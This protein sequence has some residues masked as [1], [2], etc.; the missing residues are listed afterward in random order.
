MYRIQSVN[1]LKIPTK[2]I[3]VILGP[4][5]VGKTTLLRNLY[6]DATYINIEEGKYID[7]LNKRNPDEIISL[8]DSIP[9]SSANII[10]LDEVQRL[11]DPGLVAKVLFD[12]FKN[13]IRLIL[14][15]SSSIEI[16][17]KASESLAGRSFTYNLYPLTFSERLIQTSKIELSK[18]DLYDFA[19]NLV[20]NNQFRSELL[21]S[22]QFGLYPEVQN[23]SDDS[24]K[25]EYLENYANN[26]VL[27]DLLYLGLLKNGRK[28]FDLLRLLAFQIGQQVNYSELSLR[29]GISRVTVENYLYLL[30]QIFIIF[31]LKPFTKK[32]RDEIGKTEKVYFYDMGLRNAIIRDFSPV[33][34]R[35]D[36]GSIFEN[37]IIS[38]VLK[39]N[40]YHKLRYGLYYWRTK[41]GSEVDLVLD[42]D[43]KQKA[44]EIKIGKGK[45][46]RAFLDT[47]PESEWATINLSN[48]ETVLLLPPKSSSI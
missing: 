28:I 39:L 42:K 18:N 47:Y 23:L 1:I 43:G 12:K 38:E 6:P 36:F 15:G 35:R 34:F 37:F 22:M 8:F 3:P 9:N 45:V 48:A 26:V 14:T 21:T 27:K 24:L 19:T 33:E 46:T 32:R 29:L 41:W 7:I 20:K 44:F 31:R 10:I 4:R 40:H 25:I 13:D 17:Q 16:S 11:E 30:E 5:Q 2:F